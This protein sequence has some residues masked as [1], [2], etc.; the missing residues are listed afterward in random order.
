[1][2][3]F[4]LIQLCICIL[5]DSITWD[6]VVKITDVFHYFSLLGHRDPSLAPITSRL[7]SIPL[8]GPLSLHLSYFAPLPQ[9]LLFFSLSVRF[10]VCICDWEEIIA[11][12][13]CLRALCTA[14]WQRVFLQVILLLSPTQQATKKEFLKDDTRCYSNPNTRHD[15]NKS[16]SAGRVEEMD[17]MFFYSS[18]AKAVLV[19]LE[20]FKPSAYGGLKLFKSGTYLG[21]T[22][23]V[24]NLLSG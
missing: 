16:T 5:N 3:H 18:K 17:R 9:S 24:V 2:S 1:M 22:L 14:S 7:F 10:A 12:W 15:R 23:L 19:I 4:A 20:H 21:C 13:S 11:K 8:S 6:P